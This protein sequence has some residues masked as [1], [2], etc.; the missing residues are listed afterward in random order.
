[1]PSAASCLIQAAAQW[2]IDMSLK[3]VLEPTAGGVYVDPCRVRRRKMA[4][5]ARMSEATGKD[6]VGIVYLVE[7]ASR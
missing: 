7:K 3:P 5:C 1:M 4:I 2:L 6:S